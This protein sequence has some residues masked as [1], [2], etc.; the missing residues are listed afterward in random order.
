MAY[1][2]RILFVGSFNAPAD[3]KM[4]GQYFACRSLLESDLKDDFEFLLIDSTLDS[5][6][7]RSA[8]YRLH[9]IVPRVLKCVNALV[10]SR[11][12][13]ALLFTSAGMSFVEK[14]SVGL[15]AKALGKK[16][17]L[18]PRAGPIIDDVARSRLYRAYVRAVVRSC[19]AVVCQSDYWRGFFSS[20]APGGDGDRFVVIENW[21]PESY[22]GDDEQRT[23]PRA[24]D[25]PLRL[26]YLS[27]IEREKGIYDLLEA[28]LLLQRE[29]ARVEAKI[30]GDG[31]ELEDVKRFIS[32]RGLRNTEYVGW[33]SSADKKAV[34]SSFDLCVFP[35]H[36]EGFPNALLEVMALGVPVVAS[37]VGSVNDLIEHGSNGLLVDV[38][39]PGQ[40]AQAV[41]TVLRE[42]AL[43]GRFARRSAERVRR[44]NRLD[45]AVDK[46]RSL[47]AT[48]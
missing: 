19:D 27:R 47:L 17:I 21:L 6:R 14:G 46:L 7:V 12:D 5:I 26:L 33:L 40:I 4:G 15:L 11:V 48:P 18:C 24:M 39:C 29:G 31:S 2:K 43:L 20:V 9:R 42:P 1:K 16:V 10:F 37:R 23:C 41:S 32:E 45:L 36:S 35:S 30:Y 25:R 22:F 34:I 44:I 38:E 28:M 3:G 8:F 13:A